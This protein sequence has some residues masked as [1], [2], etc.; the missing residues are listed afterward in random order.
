MGKVSIA[1]SDVLKEA[2]AGNSQAVENLFSGFLAPSE[3][4]RGCGYLG[5]LGF[6]FPEHSFWCVTTTR[7]C[8]LRIKRGGE[9]VFLQRSWA[10]PR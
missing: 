10:W 8:S 7:T 4:I 5:S 9:V 2:K 3:G 1:L 6:M